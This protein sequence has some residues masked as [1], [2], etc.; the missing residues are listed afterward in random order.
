MWFNP[1]ELLTVTSCP[2]ANLANLANSESNN[3]QDRPE[4][5]R[6]SKISSGLTVAQNKKLLAYM[7]AIDEADPEMI[8]E[9]LTECAKDANKLAWALQWANK[10][11]AAQVQPEQGLI[12]CRS[13]QHW[14]C[15]NAHGGGGGGG[16]GSCGAGVLPF[17]ACH[18][19]ETQ[20]DCGKYLITDKSRG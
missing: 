17:G 7:T 10:G 2:P 1:S 8:D 15:Y 16:A 19:S 3:Q 11:L 14:K 9:L 12:T 4:I 5:S 6:I 13:C 18:W 20:H